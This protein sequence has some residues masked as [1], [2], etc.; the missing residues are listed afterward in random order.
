MALSDWTSSVRAI[1]D[2]TVPDYSKP[3]HN[4]TRHV[5]YR[6]PIAVSPFLVTLS[7]S[8]CKWTLRDSGQLWPYVGIGW[9][10]THLDCDCNVMGDM[11]KCSPRVPSICAQDA[12]LSLLI[13][14]IIPSRLICVGIDNPSLVP[15][16]P[17]LL[18]VAPSG[19]WC[20]QLTMIPTL[21]TSKP[22]AAGV[23][24][25]CTNFETWSK[26]RKF[27]GILVSARANQ[28]ST[29]APSSLWSFILNSRCSCHGRHPFSAL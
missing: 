28:Y 22:T 12:S 16:S 9:L 18:L 11:S 1:G 21:K 4:T 25:N 3:G 17:V 13:I 2:T 7:V 19:I 10:G 26:L 5:A 15:P 29:K 20:A 23:I 27:W 14:H 24:L 8:Y 6:P